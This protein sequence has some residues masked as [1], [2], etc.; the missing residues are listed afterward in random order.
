[1]AG[2]PGRL[3]G[4]VELFKDY[5][6]MPF[7]RVYFMAQRTNPGSQFEELLIDN[8]DLLEEVGLDE[9]SEVQMWVSDL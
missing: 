5:E 9:F 8:Y 1:M 7:Q 6:I 2:A 3:P 4:G